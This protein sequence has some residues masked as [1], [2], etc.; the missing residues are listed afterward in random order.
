MGTMKVLLAFLSCISVVAAGFLRPLRNETV[1]LLEDLIHGV[2][3]AT[4]AKPETV[5]AL[6]RLAA[7]A[8][9]Q[10]AFPADAIWLMALVLWATT[11]EI[12][13]LRTQL[14]VSALKQRASRAHAT[15]NRGLTA[16]PGC[17]ISR[18]IDTM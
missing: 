8:L 17:C 4:C 10:R 1:P 18:I 9:K 12:V 6:T 16:I 15:S 2:E 5:A 3:D 13:A 11:A 14:A 7:S